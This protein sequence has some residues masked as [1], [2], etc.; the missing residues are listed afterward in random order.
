[1]AL[2]TQDIVLKLVVGMFDAAP[3]K[4]YLD[5]LTQAA[6]RSGLESLAIDLGN[7]TQFKSLYPPGM[8]HTAVAVQFA[9][10]MIPGFNQSVPAHAA[11]VGWLKGQLDQGIPVGK[12]IVNALVELYRVPEDHPV[13]GDT[14][15]FWDERVDLAENYSV[16]RGLSATTVG[17]LKDALHAPRLTGAE[18]DASTVILK[19][20]DLNHLDASAAASPALASFKVLVGGSSRAVTDLS[21]D[22]QAGT[23]TLTLS[24]AVRADQVVQ[25]SYT[26]PS[27]ADDAAAIQ[28]SA[29]NDVPSFNVTPVNVTVQAVPPPPPADRTAPVLVSPPTVDGDK[30]V[31]TYSDANSLDDNERHIP[32]TGAFTVLVDGVSP[33][34]SSLAVDADARTVTLTLDTAVLNGQSVTVAYTDP[35]GADDV[36]AIQDTAG[37]DAASFASVVV[38]NNTPDVTA[39]LLDPTS[40]VSRSTLVLNYV[41][42]NLL[43]GDSVP[44][45][46]DY[47]VTVNG[48]VRGVSGV[49]V[50]ADA[51]TVTLTL[52]SPVLPGQTV[53]VTYADVSTSDATDGSVQDASG[54]HALNFSTTVAN[55]TVAAAVL[56]F[57]QIIQ[58]GGGFQLSVTSAAGDRFGM[59]GRAAGDV[60]GDG[61]GDVIVGAPSADVNGTD[62]GASYVLFG[63]PS[64]FGS[65]VNSS[66]LDAHD[67]FR[68]D[69]AAGGDSTGF[70]VDSAGDFNGDGL[71]DLIIG[72]GGSDAGGT[73][74]GTAYVVYGKESGFGQ[75]ISLSNLAPGDGFAM[76]GAP[77][78]LVGISVSSAGDLNGDGFNDVIVS[79]ALANRAFVVFGREAPVGSA[80]DLRSLNGEDGFQ[81]AGVSGMSDFTQIGFPV[82]AAGDFNGDGVDDLLIGSPGSAR[83]DVIFGTAS[84]FASVLDLSALDGRNGFHIQGDVSQ[85]GFSVSAAGDVNGD[86]TGDLIIGAPPGQAGAGSSYVVFRLPSS[87]TAT[88]DLAEMTSDLGFRLDGMPGDSSGRSVSAAGDF[89][90]DGFGDLVI[91]APLAGASGSQPTGAGS[92][93]LVFGKASGFGTSFDLSSMDGTNGMRIDGSAS[94]DFF[95][96]SV[97]AAGDVNG[98]GFA[99][100]IIGAPSSDVNGVDSG[101]ST[102]IY[103]GNV[104]GSA[105]LVGTGADDTLDKGATS[106]E[107]FVGGAGN[108]T[109]K[110]GGGK[111]VF[112]GGAGDDAIYVTDPTFQLVDGGAGSDTLFFTG[113][114]LDLS[115]GD[116]RGQ[117]K[118]I[119]II[120]IGGGGPN[121]PNTFT[122]GAADL[123]NLSDESNTLTVRGDSDDTL[124]LVGNW[125]DGKIVGDSHTY[126]LGDAILDV[127]GIT[128]VSV[129]P[130]SSGPVS[131]TVALSTLE[132]SFGFHLNAP[133]AGDGFGLSVSAAGDVNGDGF[134]D[135]IVGA[136]F[137]D[138]L[139]GSSYIVF[140]TAA[141]VPHTMTVG[142]ANSFR[143][144]GTDSS[145]LGLSVSSAG[146]FDGDGLGDLILGA[147]FSAKN[148][149]IYGGSYIVFGKAIGAAG[150]ELLLSNL[151]ADEGIFLKGSG[152]QL[153]GCSVSAAGDINADG[154]GDVVV[155]S[156]KFG[157]SYVVFGTASAIGSSLEL[158]SLDGTNGF[159]MTGAMVDGLT[160]HPVVSNV[161]DVNGDGIDDLV[162]GAPE[163]GD[164]FV[165]FGKTGRFASSLDLHHLAGFNGFRIRGPNDDATGMSVDG[166]GDI[167]GDGIGDLIVGV[168][169]ASP[170]GSS[171]GTSYVIFGKAE[172]FASSLDL[173]SLAAQ[174]GF[175]LDG[176]AE[177]DQTG[178]SVSAAGDVNGDGIG[179]LVIGAFGAGGTGASYLLFGSTLPFGSAIDLSSIDGTNGWRINGSV[180]GDNF[181]EV[182]GA[183]GDFNGDGFGDLIVAAPGA[184]SGH[185][186]S[187]SV[188]FGG[189]VSGKVTFAGTSGADSMTAGT[190]AAEVFVAGAGNDLIVGGGGRDV[191]HAGAGN[192]NI[193]LG[194]STAPFSQDDIGLVDGGTGRD[195]LTIYSSEPVT[196]TLSEIRGKIQG[197]EVID[198]TSTDNATLH[199]NARDVL[200]LSSETHTLTIDCGSGSTDVDHVIAT[201]AWQSDGVLDGFDSYR[202]GEAVLRVNHGISITFESETPIVELSRLDGEYGFRLIGSHAGDSFGMSVAPA[203]DV[204]GDGF[205][206]V[207]IGA[208]FVDVDPGDDSGSSYVIFGKASGFDAPFDLS[209]LDGS[210][211]FR[212][213][214]TA[215]RSFGHS[216]DAAGDVNGD[217]FGDVIVSDSFGSAY[218]V[219]GADHFTQFNTPSASTLNGTN[220]FRL[221]G[222]GYGLT[223]AAAG[224]VN[225]DGLGDVVIGSRGA[226][227]GAGVSYVVY[228]KATQFASQIDLTAMDAATGFRIVGEHSGDY[229]SNSVSAAGDMNGDGFGD[230]IIGA[231]RLDAN[232]KMNIGAAYVVFGGPVGPTSID[233]RSLDSTKGFYID[234]SLENGAIGASVHAAGDVNGD[235]MDDLVIAGNA[236]ADA[237][238]LAGYVIFGA[239]AYDSPIMLSSLDGSHG[240][241]I[242]GN[243]LDALFTPW[244]VSA[245]GDV[246]GDG[247]GD[248]IVGSRGADVSANDAG[249]SYVVYGQASGFDAAIV[250]SALGADQGF[251]IDGEFGGDGSGYSVRGAGDVNGD[252]FDDVIVGAP[253][254]NSNGF[255]AGSSYVIFGGASSAHLSTLTGLAGSD[256]L[257]GT[258]AAESFTGGDGDDTM[259]GGGGA[260]VFHGG[261]GNETINVPDLNF[262][263]ADG[264]A[265]MDTLILEALGNLSGI[266][267]MSERIRGIEI[268]N[269]SASVPG[270]DLVVTPQDILQMSLPGNRLIVTGDG[271]DHLHLQGFSSSSNQVVDNQNYRAYVQ[272][273]AVVL[274][275]F[276]LNVVMQ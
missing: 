148:G 7:T 21:M 238:G 166:A 130:D 132:A 64:G 208:P 12:V 237:A 158:S 95:G 18:V 124:R 62:S 103:G 108:D 257:V 260:D 84:G 275:G 220:G 51:K 122:V 49:E 56:P 229:S 187:A 196:L 254:S 82:S 219:F 66:S 2:T 6:D 210:N 199:L 127:R 223:V 247:I 198:L 221:T 151:T 83:A 161:G 30:L 4:T 241:R 156:T 255:D 276:D 36:K 271:S 145:I 42:Q 272:G 226:A 126:Y 222:L 258:S 152:G 179:D 266:F 32:E 106:P 99:D 41:E 29:G 172:G 120:D 261:A 175:R 73:N 55:H 31:L 35:S 155:S 88:L 209:Q 40:F 162:V 160:K 250:L 101:A 149:D 129:I 75:S 253:Y 174:D 100:L 207:I 67:G 118:G 159:C 72:A 191:I 63:K 144:G 245:A 217:G 143:I 20:A 170:N 121:T 215:G 195:T 70:S 16:E 74:S 218:V 140:G 134:G 188:I 216:V 24:A 168:P 80:L 131:G 11:V 15:A 202:L 246:N 90:G 1:M 77:G 176:V 184:D 98:D 102:V 248:L 269:L 50:D 112:H 244:S 25:V 189:N 239:V 22:S 264:G 104:T 117:I 43:N 190:G 92:S 164:S 231:S 178:N 68:I 141:G 234:S 45:V 60:N 109:M 123:L 251:R 233:L 259:I 85:T 13:W 17:E 89:N 192:D 71:G 119:E 173:S 157:L 235:G 5:L 48:D 114:G 8:S 116:M 146:D 46:G 86:G 232:G 169:N 34:V 61:F 262:R 111:D 212:L 249:S 273:E 227:Y 242:E 243:A 96:R 267:D 138:S 65:T 252:G 270:Q 185:A 93:Y 27:A 153:A 110:G 9:Q 57:P 193:S 150:E 186:G 274:V 214:A 81:I 52:S 236:D 197:I 265:G 240:V 147:S 105:M 47:T 33:G 107:I 177:R 183:A 97:A 54:N 201:G 268:I 194:N 53:A 125:I 3:G 142:G 135:V 79:T 128:Q 26:D 211:G 91:G 19:F 139:N 180:A 205:A 58:E 113:A 206:D 59:S 39:P 230:L 78:D 165:V 87:M 163:S 137:S 76:H 256:R 115:L 136:P 37:N 23:V 181:G 200:A 28:D 213:Y 44:G 133:A 225:G 167:N 38:T 171:S 69:G 203:G 154:F 10:S 14:R 263:L 204:N 224:D 94:G 228:G 182:V